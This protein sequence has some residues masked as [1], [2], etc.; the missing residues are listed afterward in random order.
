MQTQKRK[1]E[2]SSGLIP[3]VVMHYNIKL[4]YIHIKLAQFPLEKRLMQSSCYS[5]TPYPLPSSYYLT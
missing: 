5:V 3:L 2:N 4:L 1:S